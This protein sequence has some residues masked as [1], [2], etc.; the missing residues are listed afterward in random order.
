MNEILSNIREL[1]VTLFSLDEHSLQWLL[2]T[3]AQSLAAL[4]AI[5]GVFVVYRL[6]LLH[7]QL[8]DHLREARRIYSTYVQKEP[9]IP[10]SSADMVSWNEVSSGIESLKRE[11]EKK[12]DTF[13]RA[14]REAK[15]QNEAEHSE[16]QVK[17]YEDR[18]VLLNERLERREK[19]LSVR[20]FLRR[21]FFCSVT[22]ISV[23]IVFCFTGLGVIKLIAKSPS[24]HVVA[25]AALSL[26]VVSVL[27]TAV[28][29]ILGFRE[30]E[31]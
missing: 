10:D 31:R 27:A 28:T 23:G 18:I 1:I 5:A 25:F 13:A 3:I 29:L 17:N 9:R 24:L 11:Y 2:S 12:V 6:Q 21:G 7:H 22:A 14:S 26:G 19:L 8:E 30:Y 15:R 4:L 16:A 20:S